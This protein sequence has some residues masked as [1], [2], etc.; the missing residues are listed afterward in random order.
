[1]AAGRLQL[2]LRFKSGWRRQLTPD[3]RRFWFLWS[4]GLRIHLRAQPL[5]EFVV[6]WKRLAA[7]SLLLAVASYLALVTAVHYRWKQLPENRVSWSAIASAPWRWEE[8]RVLRG[9]T[10]IGHALKQLQERKYSEAMFNLRAGVA[11][12]PANLDGRLALVELL[13]A[14]GENAEALRLLEAGLKVTPDSERIIRAMLSFYVNSRAWTRLEALTDEL[15]APGR[16]PP[17]TPA[18]RQR[19][20][21]HRAGML[22]ET[23]RPQDALFVVR[24]NPP[25]ADNPE[26]RDTLR[27]EIAALVRLGRMDEARARYEAQGGIEAARRGTPLVELSIARLLQD[28][29]AVETALRQLKVSDPMGV[30]SLLIAYQTWHELGRETLRDEVEREYVRFHGTSEVRLQHLAKLLV[31]LNQAGALERLRLFAMSKRFNQFAF[32]VGR[33]EIHLQRGDWAEAVKSLSSWEGLIDSLPEPQRRFPEFVRRLARTLAST[34][35]GEA[36]ALVA[37]A[38][39]V[40]G[41]LT[42]GNYLK[43]IAMLDQAGRQETALELARVGLRRQMHADALVREEAR[44]AAIVAEQKQ[45]VASQK[46]PVRPAA[47]E[48]APE[49][50]AILSAIDEAITRKTYDAAIAQIRAWRAATPAPEREQDVAIGLREVHATMLRDDPSAARFVLRR[51]LDRFTEA[52]HALKLLALADELRA[53]GAA[54]AAQALQSEVAAQ[55]LSQPEIVAALESRGFGGS[56]LI[57]AEETRRSVAAA[58]E[59][60]DYDKAVQIARLVR[61]AAPEW[62]GSVEGELTMAEFRA[63]VLSR[64]VPAAVILWREILRRSDGVR[65]SAIE[66]VREVATAGNDAART[67][68]NEATRLHPDDEAIRTLREDVERLLGEKR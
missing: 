45:A 68:A 14:A 4:V 11:R 31:E 65:T 44:L 49:F 58:L 46:A 25:A 56:A 24:A 23:N 22:I 47:S 62:L 52:D 40:R 35:T 48:E 67:L 9:D 7:I 26:A 57:S 8:L 29:P 10:A 36:S 13:L 61:R 6:Y 55:R 15:M 51:Y 20:V 60:K 43:A 17:L 19:L 33:T 16:V 27:Q 28:A 54:S 41:F 5:W 12:S 53:A 42:P 38:E 18:L 1:M 3:D 21:N 34:N 63:R 30:E 66:F 2:S 64:Q 50:A 59:A 32:D 37:H 39:A